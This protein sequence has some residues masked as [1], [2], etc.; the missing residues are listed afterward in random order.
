[1]IAH[2]IVGSRGPYSIFVH[3]WLRAASAFAPLKSLAEDRSE[4]WIL[5]DL[6]GYGRSRSVLGRYTMKEAAIDLLELM[7]SLRIPA[8]RWIGHSMGGLIIQKVAEL[9]PGQVASL[10]GIAPVPVSGIALDHRARSVYEAACQDRDVRARILNH[11]TAGERFEP[12]QESWLAMSLEETLPAV[13]ASYLDSWGSLEDIS[14]P[15]QPSSIP[16]TLLVGTR[17]PAITPALIEREFV[18]RYT[19]LSMHRIEG[20]GHFP[21]EERLDAMRAYF[22]QPDETVRGQ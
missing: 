12:P 7:E 16:L 15:V 22:A 2:E 18:P 17:D 4:R 20:A 19:A 1:M 11:L 13:L 8:A 10:V 9:A 14:P 5:A 6:R 3:G 21:V